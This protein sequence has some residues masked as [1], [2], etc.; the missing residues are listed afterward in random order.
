MSNPVRASSHLGTR[1]VS[2]EAKPVVASRPSIVEWLGR[3]GYPLL[4]LLFS[5]VAIGPAL[6]SGYW[7]GAHDARHSVYFLFEFDQAIRD[8]IL[9]PRWS[10]DLAFS[11]GYPLFNIYGPFAYFVGEAFHLAG[12]DMVNA[13]KASFALSV[14]LSGLAMYGFARRLFGSNSALVAA[15]AYV[16]LPYHLADL[17][18]RAALAESWA[19]VWFPLVFW[20]F[21]EC[22]TRPRPRAIALTAVAYALF[23]LSHNGLAMQV[24]FVLIPWI[25]FWLLLPVRSDGRFFWRERAELRNRVARTLAAGAA[26]LLGIALGGIFI[27]PWLLE[28][29]Y[30]NTEQWLAGYFSFSE[31]FV[32]LWQFFS[33]FWGFGISA[34]GAEDTF[35]FQLGLVLLLFAAGGW[36]LRAS[37]GTA[38]RARLFFTLMLLLFVFL[39]TE[40]SRFLWDSPF[41]FILS[42]AQFPWRF[43]IFAGFALA[44]LAGHAARYAPRWAVLL[45]ALLLVA[46]SYPYARAEIMPPAEGPVSHASLMRFQQSSGEMTG[47]SAWVAREDIPTWSDLADVWVS[48]G[49]VTSRFGYGDLPEGSWAGNAVNQSNQEITEVMLEAPMTARWLITYYPGWHAYRLPLDGN[50]ILEELPITPAERTG[51]LTVQAPA[52]HYRLLVRFED[53]PVRVVGTWLSALSLLLVLALLAWDRRRWEGRI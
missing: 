51:H 19:F 53:T 23:F 30:I 10:P 3:A 32:Q 12:L 36:A 18:V 9:W 27:V 42:P 35:P 38:R 16:F 17:Y 47:Q 7:W 8:G 1:P 25:L 37:D 11:Y 14:P 50:E 5:L 20:G 44:V 31:H 26:A 43:L 15:I 41:G 34:A 24:T 22:A 28:Y 39:M 29:Q 48:G 46:G 33:P 40:P 21:Y 4:V 49:E 6:G 2:V 45:L 13:V 52:G